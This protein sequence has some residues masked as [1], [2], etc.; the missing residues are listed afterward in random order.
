MPGSGAQATA[1]SAATSALARASA[2]SPRTG[3]GAGGARA[4]AEIDAELQRLE[5]AF[6]HRELAAALGRFPCRRPRASESRARVLRAAH[7]RSDAAL[8]EVNSAGA[9]A[10]VSS[11]PLPRP[12]RANDWL[13]TCSEQGQTYEQYAQLVAM[14]SGG[15]RAGTR[16]SL[17][18]IGLLP[19]VACGS[20]WDGPSLDA[21]A[22]VAA[23]FYASP[24][25]V[26]DAAGVGALPD[27]SD[28]G[29]WDSANTA[30][31]APPAAQLCARHD[32]R[33]GKC[34]LSIDQLLTEVGRM[35]AADWAELFCV[36]GVTCLDLFSASSDL[37]VAGMAAGE[38]GVA[39]VSCRRHHPHLA[40]SE[41]EWHDYGYGAWPRGAGE[42]YYA[43]R[44]HDLVDSPPAL[45]REASAAWCGRAARVLVHEVG[46]LLALDHC[47][48]YACVMQGSG[49][50]VEAH[51]APL[52]AC[53]VCL[54]KLTF[55]LGFDLAGRARA[56]DAVIVAEQLKP[57]V[58]LLRRAQRTAATTEPRRIGTPGRTEGSSVKAET[59]HRL[60]DGTP[61]RDAQG[62]EVR[63]SE[64][65]VVDRGQHR[66]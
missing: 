58:G 31:D 2:S 47:I 7:N 23:A 20:A 35:R 16:S 39:V 27:C 37:F 49:H 21:L 63:A 40:L 64:A 9:F 55:R 1:A 53:R 45:S 33:S 38:D 3:G 5:R 43:A 34:Q 19:I 59:R 52:E 42:I 17:P 29:W 13:A 15:F 25:R 11:D 26:L 60:L 18:A 56:L 50:L 65:S 57:A 14:R 6:R 44:P 22:A 51:E 61:S 32:A 12:L 66:A 4:A 8:G 48:F 30:H 36:V 24:V 41:A 62:G 54:R 46:H 28:Y 10:R